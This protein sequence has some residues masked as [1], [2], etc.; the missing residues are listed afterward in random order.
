MQ[1]RWSIATPP[2]L[3]RDHDFAALWCGRWSLAIVKPFCDFA[4]AQ[5]CADMLFVREFRPISRH[6]FLFHLFHLA[7]RKDY[8]MVETRPVGFGLF[9]LG[10]VG[11]PCSFFHHQTVLPSLQR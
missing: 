8:M 7:Q 5:T 4:R 9:G 3:H 11:S 6:S 10:C 1:R 2:D